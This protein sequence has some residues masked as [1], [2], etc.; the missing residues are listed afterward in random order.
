M[1]VQC[2]D[3]KASV[4][5]KPPSGETLRIGLNEEMSRPWLC[6]SRYLS[7]DP[8]SVNYRTLNELAFLTFV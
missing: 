2:V 3:L 6:T 1:Y 7:R 5:N 4:A 8:Q